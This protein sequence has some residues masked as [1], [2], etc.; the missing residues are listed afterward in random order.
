[1]GVEALLQPLWID[2]DGLLTPD[3]CHDGIP[4]I[5]LAPP[6]GR[7]REDGGEAVR[8]QLQLLGADL[9][10]GEPLAEQPARLQPPPSSLVELDGVEVAGPALPRHEQVGDDHVE[11]PAGA[12][13]MVPGVVDLDL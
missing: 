8:D 5:Q 2:S 11:P 13:K 4:G 1:M 7:V 12:E 6:E 10:Q 9:I 3:K